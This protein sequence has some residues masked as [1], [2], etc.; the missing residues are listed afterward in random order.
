M[1]GEIKY[2]NTNNEQITI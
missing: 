2:T 1:A